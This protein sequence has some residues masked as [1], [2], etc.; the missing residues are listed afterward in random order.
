MSGGTGC[1][2]GSGKREA[3]SVARSDADVFALVGSAV[4]EIV[5]YAIAI[6]ATGYFVPIYA[7]WIRHLL[8]LQL[9]LLDMGIDCSVYEDYGVIMTEIVTHHLR[10]NATCEWPLDNN[11]ICSKL[12]SMLKNHR[13]LA[14]DFERMNDI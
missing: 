8:D 3:G 9:I 7:I 11:I 12:K 13:R 2:G 14:A 5:P 10:S 4:G 6:R 1:A